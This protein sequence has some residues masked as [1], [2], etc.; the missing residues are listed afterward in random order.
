MVGAECVASG[1]VLPLLTIGRV[2][3]R[4]LDAVT[5]EELGKPKSPQLWHLSRSVFGHRDAPYTP[6]YGNAPRAMRAIQSSTIA[7]GAGFQHPLPARSN[8]NLPAPLN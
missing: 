3:D 5:V 8:S 4:L 1:D 7:V 2:V 6:E